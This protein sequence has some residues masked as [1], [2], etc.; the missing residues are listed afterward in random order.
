MQ[1]Q[2]IPLL[3][4]L[5]FDIETFFGGPEITDMDSDIENDFVLSD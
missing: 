5:I 1:D 4:H 3:E 2:E